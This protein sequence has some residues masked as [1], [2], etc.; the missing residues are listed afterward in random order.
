MMVL[1]IVAGP[2]LAGH[3]LLNYSLKYL[4]ATVVSTATLI[5]PVGSTILA[6]IFLRQGVGVLEALAMVIVLAGVYLSIMG[7]TGSAQRGL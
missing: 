2:M 3:T 6:Y 1:L 5:E 4:P 7:V